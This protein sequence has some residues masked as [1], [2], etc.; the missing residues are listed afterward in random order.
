VET[1]DDLQLLDFDEG[2]AWEST[3]DLTGFNPYEISWDEVLAPRHC[4]FRRPR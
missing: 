3:D 4:K 2:A 1:P